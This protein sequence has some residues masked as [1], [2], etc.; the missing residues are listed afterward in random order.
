MIFLVLILAAFVYAI[1]ELVFRYYGPMSELNKLKDYLNHPFDSSR[2]CPLC[3]WNNGKCAETCW[4]HDSVAYRH[5]VGIQERLI[6]ERDEAV[7]KLEEKAQV[8]KTSDT[9]HRTL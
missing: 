6:K 5:S 4:Y 2:G 9:N 8:E 1:I 7:S 3:K